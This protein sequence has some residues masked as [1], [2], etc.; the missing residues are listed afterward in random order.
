MAFQLV[1][2]GSMNGTQ[3]GDQFSAAVSVAHASYAAAD[4]TSTAPAA[5]AKNTRS[6]G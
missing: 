3:L 4:F 1:G 5:S 2:Q 6:L